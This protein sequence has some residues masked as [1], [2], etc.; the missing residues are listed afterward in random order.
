MPVVLLGLV[1]ALA[2]AQ[3]APE[4]PPPTPVVKPNGGTSLSPFPSVLRT[5]ASSTAPPEVRAKAAVLADLD[6]GQVLWSLDPRARRPIASVTKIMTALLVLERS[7]PTDVVTVSPTAA[8]DGR[9]AGISELG[10]VA[11]ERVTVSDLLYALMLQ[12]A[13]DAAVALAEHVSGSIDAFVA[14]M[15]HRAV[16]LGLTDTRFFSPS[17]LDDR[18]YSTAEDLLAIT[19]AA[20]RE[21]GFAGIV[22]TRFHEIP[23]S[24]GEPDRVV[25]NRNVLLWLYAGAMGVKT[26]FTSAAGYCLVAA[27]ER[28][29]QRLA[30]VVLGEPGEPF[31]DAAALLNYGFAAF[32]HR[33]VLT[34]GRPLGEV[35]IDGRPVAVEA[36][37]TLDGLVPVEEPVR[38]RVEVSPDAAFPPAPGESVGTVWVSVPGLRI[39]S[40]PLLVTS[41]DP[42]LPPEEPG[43]WW[44]RAVSAVAG[45]VDDVLDAL[46]G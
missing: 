36:G 3:A 16:R 29:G 19:R 31:S 15:N 30:A 2:G 4:A 38:R 20:Y 41:V 6:T 9:T 8:G 26:G 33:R 21:P 14:A 27:A 42:P 32:E 34:E 39:G 35:E 7:A 10:L 43:P 25:Q 22:A 28:D 13:S 46:F 45:A 5:P 23:A 18:G 17:G 40:V 1:P 37:G 44:R 12:S 11:G 24:N